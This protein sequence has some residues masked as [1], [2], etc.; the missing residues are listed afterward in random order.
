MLG[1]NPVNAIFIVQH[2]YFLDQVSCQI[3]PFQPSVT[4]TLIIKCNKRMEEIKFTM[5][6]WDSMDR[7]KT[8]TRDRAFQTLGR[9]FDFLL[10]FQ[11]LDR[12]L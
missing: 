9:A 10:R 1:D 5:A 3:L 11:K 2:F 4:A 8:Q 7:V 12:V 6:D